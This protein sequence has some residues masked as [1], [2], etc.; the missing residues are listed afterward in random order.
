M[1]RFFA[2]HPTAANLLMIGIIIMGL[3]TLPNLERETFPEFESTR[4]SIRA[5]YPGASAQEV[6]EAVAQRIENALEGVNY[7]KEVQ[8]TCVEGSV[9]VRVE[10]AEGGEITTFLDDIKS[11][12]ESITEFPDEVEDIVVSIDDR[13]ERVVSVAVTGPMSDIALKNYCDDLKDKFLSLPEVSQATVSGFPERQI[14]IE[15]DDE[16]LAGFGVTIAQ[17]ARQISSQ[18]VNLPAGTMEARGRSFLLRFDDARESVHEFESLIVISDSGAERKLGE[19]AKITEGFVDDDSKSL[20]NGKRA[21]IITI[22]KTKTDDALVVYDAVLEYLEVLR[23]E[24]PKGVS[25]ELTSDFSKIIRERISMIT[26]NAIQGLVLVFLSMWFFFGLRTAFWVAVGLPVSFLGAFYLFPIFGISVNMFTTMALLLATGILMD[27]AIV[28]SENMATHFARGKPAVQAVV[29]GI[30]EVWV[31]VVYSFLTTVSVFLPLAFITGNIGRVLKF[32]PM[33]LILV[34]MVSFIEAFLILPHHL[35]YSWK[36]RQGMRPLLMQRIANKIVDWA[37]EKIIGRLVDVLVEWRY[38]VLG[39]VILLM[40]LSFGMLS[41]GILKYEAFPGTEGDTIQCSLLMPQG[42][43][44]EE[45]EKIVERIA[46]G[47]ERVQREFDSRSSTGRIVESTSVIIG[48]NRSVDESGPH[49]ATYTVDLVD[50]DLRTVRNE[51]LLTYWREYT[52]EVAGALALQFDEAVMGPAGRPFEVRISGTDLRELKT[53]AYEIEDWLSRFDGVYDVIDNLRLGKPEISMK[54]KPGARTLGLTMLDISSQVRAAFNGSKV[55]EVLVG[56]RTYEVEVA[57]IE[58]GIETLSDLEQLTIVGPSGAAIPLSNL[59]EFESTIGWAKISRVN[60]RR[61]VTVQGAID[62]TRA[63]ALEIT[64]QYRKELVPRLARKYP[65]LTSSIEGQARRS[66]ETGVS[67]INAFLIGIIGIFLLLSFQFRSYIEPVV[68]MTAIP[69]DLIGVVF[70][71]ILV[72]VN[73][74]MPSIIGFVSLCGIVVNDSIL[75]VEFVKLRAKS[76][77]LKSAVKQASRDRFRAITM[78]SLTTIFGIGPIILET[79]FQAQ[80]VK[81]IAVSIAF[82]L[83]GTTLLVLI[84]VPCFYIILADFGL[85]TLSHEGRTEQKEAELPAAALPEIK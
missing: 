57:F 78:T 37:R 21:G 43:P 64:M 60:G 56:N 3:M 77:D 34:L 62:R 23:K 82:G 28:L 4:V 70:G 35:V 44:V 85:A 16:T 25:L 6:E 75:L 72:G 19:L 18:S 81:P 47:L 45:T 42:T 79:S 38:A 22:Y 33:V 39:F 46:K 74:S 36:G 12:V 5:G 84:V 7:V 40:F 76:R 11:E 83:A 13:T 65:S 20:Y 26:N 66:Q 29:D 31:G 32:M 52:G 67:M 2:A 48:T 73:L 14:R 8:T 59:V 10:M 54:L 9:S 49:V 1:I 69:L 15:V 51:E 63:N 55:P 53:A 61:T 80:I 30:S 17:L 50:N 68:V 71:H 41:S 58:G 27:D 24:A